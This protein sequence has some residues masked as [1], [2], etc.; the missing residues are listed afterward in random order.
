MKCEN[1][2]C[3]YEENGNC[4]LQNIELDIQGLCKDCI[5]INIENRDLQKLKFK[6]KLSVFSDD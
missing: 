2:F 3:I 5:Y 1:C 6:S 4:T